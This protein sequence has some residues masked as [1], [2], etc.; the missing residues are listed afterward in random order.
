MAII[1]T[2]VTKGGHIV[3]ID[4]DCM[5]KPG[6]PEWQYRRDEQNRIAYQIMLKA[7]EKKAMQKEA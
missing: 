2:I 6:T 5:A 3:H 7:A 1:K 4:D